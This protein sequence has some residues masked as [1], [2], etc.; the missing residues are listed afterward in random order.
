[1]ALRHTVMIKEDGIPTW[2]NGPQL[3]SRIVVA[4][5]GRPDRNTVSIEVR[6]G[7]TWKR[8]STVPTHPREIPSTLLRK[9][10]GA[11]W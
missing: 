1:M 8:R 3:E 5:D 9:P 7:P 6:S 2:V 4:I 11:A 10:S